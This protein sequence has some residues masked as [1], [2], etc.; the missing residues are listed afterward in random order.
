MRLYLVQHG[1]AVS[2]EI[3]PERPLSELGRTT[4]PGRDTARELIVARHADG[5]SLMPT[6]ARFWF[7][8]LQDRDSVTRVF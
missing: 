4:H 3:D 2:E 6:L 7:P 1:D 5:S 8:Y